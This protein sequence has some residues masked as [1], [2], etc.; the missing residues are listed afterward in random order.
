MPLP[1][2]MQRCLPRLIII[3]QFKCGTTALFDTLAGHPGV[4]LPR[5]E[6]PGAHK[7]PLNRDTCVLKEVNGA[8]ISA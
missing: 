8:T 7:C 3:G 2:G 6:T 5:S 1:G 4:L